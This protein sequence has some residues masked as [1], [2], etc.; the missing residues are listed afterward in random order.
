MTVAKFG[1]PAAEPPPCAPRPLPAGAS[2]FRSTTSKS[3]RASRTRARS[4]PRARPPARWLCPPTGTPPLRADRPPGRGPHDRGAGLRRVRPAAPPAAWP[5]CPPRSDDAAH[6]GRH[7]ASRPA[8]ARGAAVRPARGWHDRRPR[9]AREPRGRLHLPLPTAWTRGDVDFMVQVNP[10]H[11]GCAGA[12]QR[13]V[14][15]R[16]R[17]V[18]FRRLAP[19]TV[20]PL[21]LT[22]RPAN[23]PPSYPR[24]PAR[25]AGSRPLNDPGPRVRPRPRPDAR[26]D[27]PVPLGRARRS[28]RPRARH[29]L[30]RG[31]PASSASIWSSCARRRTRRPTARSA[32]GRSWSASS[33]GRTTTT[34]ATTS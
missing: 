21:A 12:C 17:D 4:P 7:H 14:A 32:K 6:R 10:S 28:R 19:V 26:P 1:D 27:Q 9:R 31:D 18:A 3:P 23:A 16:A 20:F 34:C 29:E 25:D 2:T 8:R 33:A 24:R 5:T 15:L 30:R 11:E 13:A 22:I